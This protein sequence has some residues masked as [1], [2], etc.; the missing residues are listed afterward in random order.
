MIHSLI[1]SLLITTL[2]ESIISYI[3][4]VRNF[5]DILLVI[6]ANICT[7]PIV[8]YI[9]FMIK[10]NFNYTIYIV[11][12]TILEISAFYIEGIIFKTYM[13][14]KNKPYKLSFINNISSFII[15]L[16]INILL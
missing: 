7:N 11:F 16:L 10:M 14:T 3:L 9:S 15:G 13:N 1:I 5:K 6:L 8:V 12:L 4:K 2:V